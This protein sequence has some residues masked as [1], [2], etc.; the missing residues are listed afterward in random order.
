[1]HLIKLWNQFLHQ[2]W[3]DSDE[4]GQANYFLVTWSNDSNYEPFLNCRLRLSHTPDNHR[5]I[6][7]LMSK[8]GLVLVMAYWLFY[9]YK[10]T[11]E[12]LRYIYI[13]TS[14]TLITVS[15][16]FATFIYS[17]HVLSPG[18]F[19]TVSLSVRISPLPS[20]PTP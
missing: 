2:T 13:W 12:Y 11:F 19:R 4:L 18:S 10:I 9:P 16:L 5:S 20:P 8:P 6:I 7:D 14:S 3:L 15:R 1:M 17:P